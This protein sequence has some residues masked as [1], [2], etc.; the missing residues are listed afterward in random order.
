MKNLRLLIICFV[1]PIMVKGETFSGHILNK[2]T[3]IPVEYANIGVLKKNI[4]T[5]ADNHGKYTLFIDPQYDND[6]LMVSCIGFKSQLFKIA[7]FK[8]LDDHNIYLEEKVSEVPPVVVRPRIFKQKILGVTTK[9]KL[10]SAGFEDNKLGYECGVLMKSAK[11]AILEKVNINFSYCAYDTILYRLNIYR[12]T[13]QKEF[14]NI[15][16]EPIFLKLSKDKTRETVSIDM[17]PYDLIIQGD[18]LVTLEHIR[19]LGTG[20][21]FFCCGLSGRT[22][23]RKTSQG[24]WESIPIGI[25]ISVQA[26]VEK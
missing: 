9:S 7:D 4:G 12:K 13:D 23:Y 15:L 16:Q 3:N 25:S 18:F 22:Y 21:L 8:K 1:F 2:K 11:S 14:E 20:R 26:K 24:T 19:D 6:T 10:A 5:V 17:K